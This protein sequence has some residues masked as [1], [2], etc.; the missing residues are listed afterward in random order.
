MLITRHSACLLEGV[1]EER[2]IARWDGEMT[3][4]PHLERRWDWVLALLALLVLPVVALARAGA[5]WDLRWLAIGAGSLWL[6]TFLLYAADKSRAKAGDWRIA[7]SVL[8]CCSL[9]GGWPGAFVGQRL[10]RHKTQKCSFQVVFWITVAF[11]Q[12]IALDYLLKW[13]MIR[14]LVR[15]IGV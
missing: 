4:E 2:A 14:A 11:H 3:H 6:F 15:W 13:R 12:L 5:N 1:L 10:F 8:H 9:I 7:E